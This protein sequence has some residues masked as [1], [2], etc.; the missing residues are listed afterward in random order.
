MRRVRTSLASFLIMISLGPHAAPLMT[1]FDGVACV[2]IKA[3][4]CCPA[5]PAAT[6]PLTARCHRALGGTDAA[7]RCRHAEQDAVVRYARA[8]VPP[9]IPLVARSS[10]RVAFPA[11]ASSA[12]GGFQRV[13]SPP[14][15]TSFL[16]A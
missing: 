6:G 11:N 2:C 7:V 3:A 4:C 9:P 13:E 8:V 5:R 1:W 16:S 12:H 14:P 10:E 15:R